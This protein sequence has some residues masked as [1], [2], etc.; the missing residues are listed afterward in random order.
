MQQ[1]AKLRID[2][3]NLFKGRKQWEN[4]VEVIFMK[5]PTKKTATKKA[6][7]S[8]KPAMIADQSHAEAKVSYKRGSVLDRAGGMVPTVELSKRAASKI[9]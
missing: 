5:K 9:S 3:G 4:D 7:F 1:S 6:S 8:K 2:S